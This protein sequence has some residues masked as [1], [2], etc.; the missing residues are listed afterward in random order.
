V[1]DRRRRH[2]AGRWNLYGV[3]GRDRSV[4]RVFDRVPADEAW[5]VRGILGLLFLSGVSIFPRNE[6]RQT[7]SDGERDRRGWTERIPGWDNLPVILG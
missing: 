4:P 3:Q 2:A 6:C 7:A 5:Q 1:Q